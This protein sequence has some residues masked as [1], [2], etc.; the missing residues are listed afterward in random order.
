MQIES[1]ARKVAGKLNQP[2]VNIHL[3][4]LKGGYRVCNP[5]IQISKIK[6]SIKTKQ[7][8]EDN[9]LEKEEEKKSC[10]FV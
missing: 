3:A 1:L 6:V 9:P 4:D 5:P 7:K 10:K 2:I 8:I